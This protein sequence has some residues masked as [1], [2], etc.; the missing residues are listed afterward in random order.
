MPVREI[1]RFFW[2]THSRGWSGRNPIA[3]RVHP[4]PRFN[5]KLESLRGLAALAVCFT[6][7]IAIYRIDNSEA[8]WTV[9]IWDQSFWAGCLTLV[10]AI[11]NPSAAVIL[12]FILSGYVLTQ[13]LGGEKSLTG[14]GIAGFYV[15]RCFRILPMMWA[16]LVL[17]YALSKINHTS[18]PHQATK[19]YVAIFQHYFHVTAFLRNFF[20][21]G[22]QVSPVM[23][24]MRVELLG[25]LLMPAIVYVLLHCTRSQRLLLLGALCAVPYFIHN[26][27]QYMVCFY[28]GAL[29]TSKDL[30]AACAS[31]PI[32]LVCSGMAICTMLRIFNGLASPYLVET[33]ATTAGAALVLLG[34]LAGPSKFG[35]L[36]TGPF[37]TVGR[38]SYSLYLLH[39]TFLGLFAVAAFAIGLYPTLSGEAANMLIFLA[40]VLATLTASA[41][42]HRWIEQPSIALGKVAT[43]FASRRAAD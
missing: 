23:W 24:T 32:L 18:P 12:F 43:R 15:R 5:P 1:D 19:F 40:S 38:L 26:D 13:S 37:R 42:S 28:I 9:P 3:L 34:V 27:F 17:T 30:V 33:L 6:H 39:P 29:L 2:M 7:S 16:A 41:F 10:N 8:I 4:Q 21:L 11:F 22:F 20:L 36:E 25:S 14:K 31:R 35:I